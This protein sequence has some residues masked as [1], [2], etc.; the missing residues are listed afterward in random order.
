[1]SNWIVIFVSLQH[2]DVSAE[3]FVLV[4]ARSSQNQ[5]LA[6]EETFVLEFGIV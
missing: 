6:Y 3:S 2:D 5:I 4:D 1:M